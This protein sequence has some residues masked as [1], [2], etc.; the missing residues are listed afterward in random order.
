MPLLSVIIPMFNEE[1]TIV[2]TLDAVASCGYSP[3]IIVVDDGSSDASFERASLWARSPSTWADIRIIKHEKNRGKGSAIRSALDLAT[4]IYTIVQ[5]A[6]LECSPSDYPAL[7]QPLLNGEAEVVFGSRFLVDGNTVRPSSRAFAL[8]AG[9][10]IRLL[11]GRRISDEAG[12]YKVMKTSTLRRLNP[13]S[14]RFEFCPEVVA[15]VFRSRL[16]WVEVPVSFTPRADPSGKKIGLSDAFS[17]L[18][19]LARWRFARLDIHAGTA[20]NG[21]FAHEARALS[22]VASEPRDPSGS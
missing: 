8:V 2:Q 10:S 1:A 22:V 18:F 9:L 3:E 16:A 5:D 20:R 13:R 15:K 12:C 14:R 4:G 7:L 11:F 17:A 6:D 19:T 21:A